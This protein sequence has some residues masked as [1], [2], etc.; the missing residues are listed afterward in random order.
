MKRKIDKA[1]KG[2]NKYYNK[3]IIVDTPLIE[4]NATEIRNRVKEGL[5]IDF[6]VPE[7]VKEYI[8]NFKLYRN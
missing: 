3:A 2:K 8:Y 4:I 1:P 7:I 5:P 6:L